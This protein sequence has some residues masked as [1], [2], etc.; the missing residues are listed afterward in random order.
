MSAFLIKRKLAIGDE[1]DGFE[2]KIFENKLNNCTYSENN[3]LFVLCFS[4]YSNIKNTD[5]NKSDLA[6]YIL[7]N[8]PC[9]INQIINEKK[10]IVSFVVYDKNSKEIFLIS[11][12]L[13][14][15][16]IYYVEDDGFLYVS[17]SIRVLKSNLGRK[18][19]VYEDNIYNYLLS[20][21]PKKGTT[22]YESVF[23]A[24]P[25]SIINYTKSGKYLINSYYKFRSSLLNK[26]EDEITSDVKTIFKNIIER[27]IQKTDR[28]IGFMLSG[29]LDSSS[30]VM[31][32]N[33]LNLDK[34]LS[35]N[36][37]TNS[38]VFKNLNTDQFKKANEFS[39][40]EEVN[41]A[42]ESE[43]ILHNF[44]KD[45]SLKIMDKLLEMSEPTLGPNVY[46]NFTILDYLRKE[47]VNYLFDGIGGDS[48][49]SH[50]HARFIELGKR[51]Q[52]L[53]LMN[54]YKLYCNK[55]GIK[56]S[57]FKCIKEYLIKPITP[58]WI[59]DVYEKI[60]NRPAFYNINTFLKKEY[61]LDVEN[62]YSH[63]HGYKPSYARFG[64]YPISFYEEL[65]LN[66]LYEAYQNRITSEISE[67]FE[68]EII[69]P[70]NARDLREYCLNVPL[71]YK[72]QN[73]LNRSYF[74]K[75]MKDILPNKISSRA[76]KADLSGLFVNEITNL[77]KN[78]VVEFIFKD[79]EL[80]ERIFD[81][82]KV[83]AFY[84]NTKNTNDQQFATYLYKL[85]YLSLW[86]KKNCNL[87]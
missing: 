26:S 48:A 65:P 1:P 66:D 72:M 27:N 38:A 52:V 16:P 85:I 62:G 4:N 7:N 11:D 37:I 68:I 17:S 64:K 12:H 21:V 55:K 31:M 8:W 30:I 35:K 29:G 34:K 60:R 58:L 39:F 15:K 42:I 78:E 25:N 75:S 9:D 40:I 32:A 45:G 24:E 80:F 18:L 10:A 73:G 67:N 74:R 43:I 83:V 53:T 28:N 59:I 79:N 20:G 50:G 2:C 69:F 33:K 13:N 84:N 71:K 23:C 51:F 82:E 49:I 14:M 63:L 3:N 56:F 41:N 22:I 19:N 6:I 46:I 54:E 81:K 61:H 77:S 47:G 86:L 57:I 70:F 44:K 5:W 76:S 36:L 87:E